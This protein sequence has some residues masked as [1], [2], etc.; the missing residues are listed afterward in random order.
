MHCYK[1]LA[2]DSDGNLI[3][4]SMKYEYED[5]SQTSLVSYPHLNVFDGTEWKTISGDF[6]DGVPP[7]AVSTIGNAIYYIYG[8]AA[9]INAAND[10]SAIKSR[11]L[12][13]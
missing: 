1:D 8:D 13:K 6:T 7:V 10:P 12:T 11:K 2:A 4:A 9:T 5:D 3:V